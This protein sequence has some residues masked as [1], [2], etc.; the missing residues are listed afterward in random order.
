MKDLFDE[1]CIWSLENKIFCNTDKESVV[2]MP[3]LSKEAACVYA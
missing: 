3:V 1:E 2:V